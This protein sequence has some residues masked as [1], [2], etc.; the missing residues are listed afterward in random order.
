MK[1]VKN[2][3]V[4]ILKKITYEFQCDKDGY[5][6]D[7]SLNDFR[8]KFKTTI[9]FLPEINSYFS[10]MESDMSKVSKE[11]NKLDV[12]KI[13]KD[14]KILPNEAEELFKGTKDL[15]KLTF[16]SSQLI[17]SIFKDSLVNIKRATDAIQGADNGD[18]HS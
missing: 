16:E 10:Q 13:M 14:E 3:G 6:I 2:K 7:K 17:M 1:S 9:S 8:K 5:V 4:N 11:V 12:T 18:I 15:F